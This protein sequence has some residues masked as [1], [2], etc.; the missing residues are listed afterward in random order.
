L[1]LVRRAGAVIV[2]P[3]REWVRIKGEAAA[4]W[5]LFT[6]YAMILAAI[7]PGAT[8]IRDVLIRPALYVRWHRWGLASALGNAVLSYLSALALVVVFALILTALAP[9]FS[10]SRDMGAALKLSV[11]SMTPGW[12]A[13]FFF[14]FP[15]AVWILVIVA[16]L[17]GVYIF[18]EG[19]EA[20]LLE[21]PRD[22]VGGFLGVSFLAVLA[23]FTIR[24]MVLSWIFAIRLHAF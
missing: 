11:F 2:E 1:E 23:L 9:G 13:G 16:A 17:Y 18:Y 6:A 22:R 10:S 4:P 19:L 3:R 20:G 5:R 15:R 14:L 8:F 7:P 12:L 24:W 21:T